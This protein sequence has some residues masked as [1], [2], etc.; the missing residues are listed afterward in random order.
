[1]N[2]SNRKTGCIINELQIYEILANLTSGIVV[3]LK[4][5]VNF[6]QDYFQFNIIFM[7]EDAILGIEGELYHKET[8][9]FLVEYVFYCEENYKLDRLLKKGRIVLKINGCKKIIVNKKLFRLKI[10][11][12]HP[13]FR[14]SAYAQGFKSIRQKEISITNQH[15]I[16][17]EYV[18]FEPTIF[19]KYKFLLPAIFAFL[20][21][22]FTL[23]F[24]TSN[25]MNEKMQHRLKSTKAPV[26][27]TVQKE[28]EQSD[29]L[30][31]NNDSAFHIKQT[32]NQTNNNKEKEKVVAVTPPVTPPPPVV[33]TSPIITTTPVTTT[34]VNESNFKNECNRYISKLDQLSVTTDDVN[35]AK[36][37]LSDNKQSK[38]TITGYSTLSN[39]VEALEKLFSIIRE[40]EVNALQDFIDANPLRSHLSWAQRRHCQKVYLGTYANANQRTPDKYNANERIKHINIYTKHHHN[41]TSLAELDTEKM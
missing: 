28:A 30:H 38:A 13:F 26:H 27:K 23:G 7:N 40:K 6:A 36:Q 32:V 35:T 33:T 19:T 34:P 4:N 10:D 1:L 21:L 20:L 18:N 12:N 8:E 3:F 39:K 2:K 9:P 16:F 29:S 22:F 14:Y 41:Y 5:M 11:G 31:L 24:L 37:W 25:S 17:R 15:V